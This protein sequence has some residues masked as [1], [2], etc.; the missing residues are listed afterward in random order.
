MAKAPTR[1]SIE[2]GPE[3]RVVLLVGREVFLQ[4]E[5]TDRLR[6][7]LRAAHGGVDTVRFDGASTAPAPVLDECR[8]YGLMQQHKLVIVDAADQFVKEERRQIVERYAQSPADGATLVLRAE[9]WNRGKLDA[10]IEK[11]GI[12]VP[13]ESPSPDRAARWCVMRC[14]KHHGA[15]IAEAAA[16]LLVERLGAGLARLDAELAKLALGAEGLPITA[17]QVGELVGRSSEEEAWAVQGALLRGDAQA[18]VKAIRDSI[19]VAGNS[20]M[21]VSWACVDLARKVHGAA[22]GLAAGVDRRAISK[23]YRMW[24]PAEYTVF[25]AAERTTP[26]KAAELFEEAVRTD[27]LAKL[28]GDPDRLLERLALKFAEV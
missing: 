17:V 5:Y 3:H 11:V 26:A 22:R 12:I 10:L 13:C 15:K 21:A 2:P 18:A 23:T 25:A 27:H 20:P 6:E 8:T 14:E 16:R 4:I 9:K 24:G 19:D 7:K 1:V 28:G